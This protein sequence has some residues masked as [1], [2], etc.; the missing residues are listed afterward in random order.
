MYKKALY[1]SKK[2]IKTEPKDIKQRWACSEP[3]EQE[4]HLPPSEI[5]K[6]IRSSSLRNLI[7]DIRIARDKAYDGEPLTPY[8]QYLFDR[9]MESSESVEIL[10]KKL[11]GI[12]R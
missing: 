12:K 10:A 5:T 9:F 11:K 3:Q 6:R 4:Q 8:E 7:R 2:W 1:I